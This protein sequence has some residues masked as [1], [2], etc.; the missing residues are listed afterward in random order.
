MKNIFLTLF[1][2]ST[3]LFSACSTEKKM[4]FNEKAAL[5]FLYQ[6]MPLDD[7]VDYTEDYYRECVHYA[8]LAKQEMPWGNSIPEREFKHFVVPVRVNNEHLDNCREVFYRTLKPR[9]EGMTMSEAVLEVN[10][11]CHEHV[12]Y[13]P[14]DARTSSPLATVRTAYGRCGEESTLLVAALRSV[15]IPARQVY[16]WG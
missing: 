8:F 2:L 15:G 1:A 4:A 3:L 14:S 10:H 13:R 9:V 12:T 16:T 6:Y 5:E 7:S 11:W